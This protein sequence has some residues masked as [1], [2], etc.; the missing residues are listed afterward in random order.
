[1]KKFTS[2]LLVIAAV[3]MSFQVQ[4]EERIKMSYENGVYTMPCEVNGLR[5]K[6][7]FDTGASSVC[8][9]ATEALF[10]IKNGYLEDSDFAGTSLAQIASG[11][12]IENFK[13][14]LREIKIGSRTLQNVDFMGFLYNNSS[15]IK[16]NFQ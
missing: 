15:Q 12:V 3:F 7:I 4:A 14:T 10:M 6:F 2:I 5:M 1:M 16:H 11:E 8:I 13:I 9:S